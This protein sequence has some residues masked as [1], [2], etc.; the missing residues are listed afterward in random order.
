MGLINCTSRTNERGGLDA[1]WSKIVQVWT[2]LMT[3]T[4]SWGKFK[5]CKY[6]AAMTKPWEKLG[7]NPRSLIISFLLRLNI[8]WLRFLP[9]SRHEKWSSHGTLG[10]DR[11]LS[12]VPCCCCCCCCGGLNLTTNHGGGES[13]VVV[14][15]AFFWEV[16]PFGHCNLKPAAYYCAIAVASSL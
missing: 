2:C 14:Y 13:C 15:F 1:C 4:I 16:F 3:Q 6:A 12:C 7:G 5:W 8:N 9:H 11:R 10:W